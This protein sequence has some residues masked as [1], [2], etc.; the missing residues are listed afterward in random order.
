MPLDSILRKGVK[1]AHRVTKSIQGEVL[2]KHWVDQD[3]YGNEVYDPPEGRLLLAVIDQE[4]KRKMLPDGQLVPV[5]ATLFFLN[6]P[7]AVGP[8][9]KMV[10]PDGTTGPLV[11]SGGVQDP[12]NK[13][14]FALEVWL[15][16]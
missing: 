2:H 9:D 14:P 11:F 10:L 1:I 16:T 13:R 15:G 12:K 7:P 5:K 4:F 3:T 6:R 8:K